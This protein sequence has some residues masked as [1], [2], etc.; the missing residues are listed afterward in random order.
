MIIVLTTNQD[1]VAIGCVDLPRCEYGACD[2]ATKAE[3]SA[4]LSRSG[5]DVVEK[6]TRAPKVLA[7]LGLVVAQPQQGGVPQE[8]L[9]AKVTS[10]EETLM[11]SCFPLG[12]SIDRV[13]HRSLGRE[14]GGRGSQT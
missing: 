10:S 5:H 12:G 11:K 13:W 4:G 3:W 6:E 7:P 14:M 2:R 8:L 1:G 9:R